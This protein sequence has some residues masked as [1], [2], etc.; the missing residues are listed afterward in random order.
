MFD[1][2]YC[3][4]G[5]F[6]LAPR[7]IDLNTEMGVLFDDRPLAEALRDEYLRLA[8]PDKSYWV[9]LNDDGKL[10]WL[11]A[12][13]EPPVVLTTEPD[14]TRFQRAL[15]WLVGW[16]PVESQLSRPAA[17]FSRWARPRLPPLPLAGAGRGC[18]APSCST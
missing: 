5:S 11:D 3:N 1:D 15:S 10:R 13:A 4:I 7:S 6:Y 18:G 9:Y 12:A 16:L 8:G 17:G 2:R 14:S